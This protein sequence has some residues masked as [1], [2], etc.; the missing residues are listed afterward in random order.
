LKFAVSA[1]MARKFGAALASA[2]LLCLSATTAAADGLTVLPVTIQLAPGQMATSLTV[3]NEAD[4]ATSLQ[5]RSFA[6]NQSAQ[7]EDRLEPT[8]QLMASPPISTIAAGA[9]QVIRLV[10]R[11]PAQAREATYRIL[12]DQI[13][14]PALPGTVRIALRL[15]IPIFAEPNERATPHLQWRVEGSGGEAALVAVNDGNR[16]EKVLDIALLGAGRS[17]S[18]EAGASPYVLAGATR[19][20]RVLGPYLPLAAGA[21]LRLTARTDAGA[22]DQSVAVVAGP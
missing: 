14:P 6:W 11:Q 5:V 12:L 13:P 16:H 22:I 7:G 3:K 19:R 15:S 18:T 20:W 9:S 21:T 1:A 8:T 2:L 4:V 17:L 10:L